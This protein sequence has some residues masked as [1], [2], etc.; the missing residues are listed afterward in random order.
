MLN[1]KDLYWLA[2]LLEGEGYFG[3][4]KDGPTNLVF[5]IQ[6]CSTDKD[7]IDRASNI[8]LGE[9]RTSVSS[10]DKWYR[11]K[12]YFQVSTA[13]KHAIQWMMTLY[14]LMG[15]RRKA[16]IKE[17]IEAWKTHNLP[18]DKCP[19][20]HTYT[21]GRYRTGMRKGEI[22]RRCVTCSRIAKRARLGL[23]K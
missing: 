1:F 14:S 5:R 3:L 11:H 7:V 10:G 9:V 17:I 22:I 23:D 18:S 8:I 16:R 2:G 21:I 6:V 20:G 13:G 19:K 15:T 12:D 4:V